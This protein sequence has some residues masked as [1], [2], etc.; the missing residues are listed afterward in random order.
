MLPVGN[1]SPPDRMWRGR[2][3]GG[4]YAAIGPC[5]AG[6]EAGASGYW[7]AH[8]AANHTSNPRKVAEGMERRPIES[9]PCDAVGRM[10]S[11]IF[12]VSDGQVR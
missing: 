9:G 4:E 2:S 10:L 5:F 8:P 1:P 11:W 6:D 12:L 3:E 7:E